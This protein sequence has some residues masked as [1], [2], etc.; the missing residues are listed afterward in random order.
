M[1]DSCY[2]AYCRTDCQRQ[3]WKDHNFICQR[4]EFAG[5]PCACL[6]WHGFYRKAVIC[7]SNACFVFSRSGKGEQHVLILDP[8]AKIC[9]KMTFGSIIARPTY[10]QGANNSIY[11]PCSIWQ[12]QRC[13]KS[14]Q[15]E[16]L[17]YFLL[18]IIISSILLQSSSPHAGSLFVSKGNGVV[19]FWGII[20][21]LTSMF[22]QLS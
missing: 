19:F 18:R 12:S 11:R 10:H 7:D 13:K 15:V 2:T 5:A 17:H 8:V 14:N 9:L 21:I 22:H 4:M 20:H 6:W 3:D 16:N 1:T